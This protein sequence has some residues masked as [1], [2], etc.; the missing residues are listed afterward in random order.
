MS[1]SGRCSTG[2]VGM[3]LGRFFILATLGLTPVVSSAAAE[4]PFTIT[5]KGTLTTS[6]QLFP[7]PDSPDPLERAEFVPLENQFGMG[8]EVRYAFPETRL[9]A[10][11]S[12]EYLEASSSGMT[13]SLIPFT[14]GYRV[15]PVELTAF[16]LIPISGPSL[17]VYMGGGIGAYIGER[18]YSLAGVDAPAVEH[19]TGVGIHV[20]GGVTVRLNEMFG[21]TGEMK[22][23]DLQ[24]DAANEFPVSRI[25]H[26]GRVIEV[27]TDAFSSQV[28]T[29]GVI[30]QLGLAVA[31]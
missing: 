16:F 5:L 26:D 17:D 13:E 23:R 31:F 14:D 29:D 27:S 15:I 24:F 30:F 7:N 3:T 6:S 12:A 4:R 20:L 25:Y 21:V 28:H 22:F 1:F 8:L 18:T 2:E 19:R 11:L 10:S 9:A